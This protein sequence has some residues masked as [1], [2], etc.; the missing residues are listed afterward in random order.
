MYKNANNHTTKALFL[1]VVGVAIT[2]TLTLLPNTAN[3]WEFETC[4][5]TLSTQINLRPPQAMIMLDRSG[6]M[7][8]LLENH[9]LDPEQN[10]GLWRYFGS[11]WPDNQRRQQ[12]NNINANWADPNPFPLYDPVFYPN[13]L[14]YWTADFRNQSPMIEP[15]Y[16]QH[17]GSRYLRTFWFN[18][19]RSLWDVAIRELKAVLAT[20]D[21]PQ[22]RRSEEH[23]SELQSRPHLVCRLLLEK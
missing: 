17:D 10:W 3:A 22:P 9:T 20:Y 6:S 18:D 14:P 8:G 4:S 7:T 12:S 1:T 16:G 2:T 15:S 21:G 11:I 13:G 19:P 5:S 23:T